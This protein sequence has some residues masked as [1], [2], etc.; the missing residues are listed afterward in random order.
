[1]PRKH[2]T[3][4]DAL[5]RLEGKVKDNQ[6]SPIA[7]KLQRIERLKQAAHARNERIRR[8]RKLAQGPTGDDAA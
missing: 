3:A 5:D 2:D 1:M 6:L 8:A 7:E 4:R